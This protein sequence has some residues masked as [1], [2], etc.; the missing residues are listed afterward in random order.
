MISIEEARRIIAEKVKPLS[1]HRTEVD[2]ANQRVLREDILADATYPAAD[3]SM[4]DGYAFAEDDP[5]E[6]F[7]VVME[8]VAGRPERRALRAGECAR[9]FTGAPLP[10][11]AT[12]VLPQED[13]RREGDLMIPLRRDGRRFVRPRGS[14]AQAG[15]VLLRKGTRI[16]PGERAILAQAG[17][18]QPLVSS[19]PGVWHVATGDELVDPREQPGAGEIRDSNSALLGA[20]T[21]GWAVI[22]S[23]RCCDDLPALVATCNGHG[24][25]REPDMLLI[26][27]GASVGERDFGARV[28]RE[29]GYTIH[30]DRVNLRP[31]KPL[32]FATGEDG[33]LAFVIPGNPV[34]HFVCYHVAIRLAIDLLS[35][36]ESS[37]SFLDVVLGGE[38][39]LRSDPRET[40]WPA[41]VVVQEGKL[42]ALPRRWTSSGDTFSLAGAN[43]LLRVTRE[44]APGECVPTLLLEVLGGD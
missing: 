20:L 17:C 18:V 4:M 7:R 11:G 37:W 33:R 5:A 35:A 10:A 31:G 43:A 40:F 24:W 38:S 9:I 2:D 8:V 15:D 39:P 36:T 1:A 16:G 19:V 21:W 30:F 26:S 41:R 44:V 29:L 23:H 13:A 42:V 34:S 22:E 6:H 14:E 28:L 32:T 27:G 12:T 25:L 3:C